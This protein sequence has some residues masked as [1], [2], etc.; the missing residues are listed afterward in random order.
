MAVVEGMVV[1]DDTRSGSSTRVKALSDRRAMSGGNWRNN[2][3]RGSAYKGF[4]MD[5]LGDKLG[6]AGVRRNLKASDR[7][8]TGIARNIVVLAPLG[9]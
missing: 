3:E 7:M 8:C 1:A 9:C 5:K 2:D 6:S 4:D